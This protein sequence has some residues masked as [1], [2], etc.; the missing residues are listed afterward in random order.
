M[1]P[2]ILAALTL[3]ACL[4]VQAPA[5]AY[6]LVW[7][8]IDSLVRK[9]LGCEHPL[10]CFSVAT[11]GTYYRPIFAASMA[12]GFTLAGSDPMR[13]EREMH[14]QN[15][16]FFALELAGVLFFFSAIFGGLNRQSIVAMAI[17]GLHPMQASAV[18]W[19]T[20]RAD[21][22]PTLFSAMA[23]GAFISSQ[24]ADS[25][26]WLALGVVAFGLAVFS[27]EQVVPLIVLV[28][29]VLPRR[30]VLGLALTTGCAGAWWVISQSVLAG[31]P[32]VDPQWSFADHASVVIRTVAH[33]LRLFVLPLPS[34]LHRITAAP[35]GQFEALEVLLAVGGS[36]LWLALG[37]RLRRAPTVVLWAFASATVVPVLNLIPLNLALGPY[38]LIL[39]LVGVAG[40]VAS[41]IK[42]TVH[43]LGLV[44]P[45]AVLAGLTSLEV[46]NWRSDATLAAA[47]LDADPESMD[48]ALVAAVAL[49]D[50]HDTASALE[51]TNG[52]VERVFLDAK[53]VPELVTR[54]STPDFRRRMGEYS[55]LRR[56]VFTAFHGAGALCYRSTLLHELHR[57]DEEAIDLDACT[58]IWWSADWRD[59]Y[60]E[61]LLASGRAAEARVALEALAARNPSPERL[62]KLKAMAP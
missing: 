10:D 28:P 14:L 27:K 20:G 50:H 23:I 40:L 32:Q 48:W 62:Q 1:P 24:R 16:V 49:N 30:K 19:V 17:F 59:K 38:R 13:A 45:L 31:V 41:A 22:L 11:A 44:V 15:L 60:V 7:D 54:A 51:L 29:L 58:Q 52:A 4:V 6:E 39:P 33:S 21:M 35:W 9:N 36:A 43:W 12:G 53:T 37:V 47:V 61:A 34:T 8:D 57:F 3:V 46:P 26:R 55:T 5:L 18:A 56:Q 2:R 25:R 42:P